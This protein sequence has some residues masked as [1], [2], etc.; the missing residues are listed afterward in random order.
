MKVNYK[1]NIEAIHFEDVAAG[2]VFF[3]VNEMYEN[4]EGYM[5]DACGPFLKAE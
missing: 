5:F 3:F 1:N 4:D 2:N